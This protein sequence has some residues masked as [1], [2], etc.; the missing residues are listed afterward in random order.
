[1][2]QVRKAQTRGHANFGWLD[3]WHTFSFGQY[4]D[5]QYMGF[6]ALRVIND[7]RIAPG[8]GFPMHGHEDMEII[9]YV[10]EGALEHRDSLDNQG[11]IRAGEVQRMRAGTGIRHSERNASATGWTHLLQIWIMPD[12]KGLEPGYRQIKLDPQGRAG[13]L[14]LIASPDG[15]DGSV[16]I[17]QNASIYAAQLRPGD[18]ITWPVAKEQRA[19]LQ[20]ASGSLT[21]NDYPFAEG[22]GAAVSGEAMLKLTAQQPAEILLFELHQGKENT[23]T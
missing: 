23:S 10:M 17:H 6:G 5:P 19:Y 15:R 11:V 18:I 22:D 8:T 14:Q 20:V 9:T 21:L 16:D 13:R 3:T 12:Q 4:Y 1:M 7:D 2:I